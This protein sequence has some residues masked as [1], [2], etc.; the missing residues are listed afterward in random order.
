MTPSAVMVFLV[1]QR[2]TPLV[3]SW[4]TMTRRE[5]KPAERGKPIMRLQESC[6][7]GWVAADW[8]GVRGGMVGCVLNLF[9]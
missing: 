8:M 4:L 3:S 1:E 7:N 5:S 6:W 2:L 9:C